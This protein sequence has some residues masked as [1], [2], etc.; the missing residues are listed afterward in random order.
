MD[1]FS[2]KYIAIYIVQETCCK[3][4]KFTVYKDMIKLNHVL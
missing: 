1:Y 2:T 3:W 4:M